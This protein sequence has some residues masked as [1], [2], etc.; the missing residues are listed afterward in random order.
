MKVTVTFVP[1][2]EKTNIRM[3][4]MLLELDLSMPASKV[5]LFF[6]RVVEE[7]FSDSHLNCQL[8]SLQVAKLLSRSL[9]VEVEAIQLYKCHS[10]RF[11]QSAL[12]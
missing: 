3:E 8:F 6:S 10:A 1:K 5:N 12:I 2:E 11:S 7:T 4:R 9:G